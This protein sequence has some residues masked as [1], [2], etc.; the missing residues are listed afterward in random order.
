MYKHLSCGDGGFAQW[1]NKRRASSWRLN[2]LFSRA[3]ASAGGSSQL[4]CAII[5]IIVL[6]GMPLHAAV[7]EQKAWAGV[8]RG[9]HRIGGAS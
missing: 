9:Y 7:C 4:L 1:R 8:A 3:A 5:I 2:A 6:L